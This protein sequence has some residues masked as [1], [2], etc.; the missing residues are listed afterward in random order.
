MLRSDLVKG[1]HI[2][3]RRLTDLHN[4]YCC[5]EMVDLEVKIIGGK[6]DGIVVRCHD[7]VSAMGIHD[8]YMLLA[9][10]L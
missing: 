3:T 7:L 10:L 4:C 8:K 5:T 6:L 1:C 2:V 9:R